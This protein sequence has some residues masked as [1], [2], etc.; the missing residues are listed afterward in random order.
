MT[1]GVSG[2]LG[3]RAKA[4]LGGPNAASATADSRRSLTDMG[5]DVSRSCR[6]RGEVSDAL[7]SNWR[8]SPVAA[9]MPVGVGGASGC[10]MASNVATATVSGDETDRGLSC[11]TLGLGS[12]SSRSTGETECRLLAASWGDV[13]V[14]DTRGDGS[15]EPP[16]DDPDR[17]D[18]IDDSRTGTADICVFS[19]DCDRPIDPIPPS[20]DACEYRL[21]F[22]AD[23]GI[24][25]LT[26]AGNA[27]RVGEGDEMWIVPSPAA[28]AG[29]DRL[30]RSP[31]LDP[32]MTFGPPLPPP[33]ESDLAPPR[34]RER[35]ERIEGSCEPLCA[36]S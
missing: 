13:G 22:D 19:I 7:E 1:G 31:L 25:D 3:G 35:R 5:I 34:K 27:V 20:I 4:L 23:V 32:R 8:A 26:P 10:G 30:S 15:R 24:P 11:I 14:I 2:G 17:P 33:N 28:A 18:R 29:V 9:S 36:R 6:P 12:A 16:R 21:G